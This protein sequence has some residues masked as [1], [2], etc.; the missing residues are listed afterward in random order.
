PSLAQT[1]PPVAPRFDTAIAAFEASDK[2]AMP[3]RCATLFVGASSIRF[4]T[5]LKEDFPDRTVINRGFGGSTVWEVDHYFDRVVAPYH[6]KEIVF[7]AGEN[8]LWVDKRTPDQ[9][10]ADFIQ[11]MRLKEK[12][13]GATPVWY[14]SAK[15]SK[16]RFEQFAT[17]VELNAKMKALADQRDDLAFIDIVPSMLKPDGTPKDIFVADNLHMTPDGYKLWTPIVDAALDAGQSA[18][19]PGC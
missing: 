16:Q 9:I 3:P 5:T 12:A 18:K 14:I 13:L 11:F 10:Y 7:Y 1:P 15:P 17:Q 8:D 4:W 19:A 6:P 2:S